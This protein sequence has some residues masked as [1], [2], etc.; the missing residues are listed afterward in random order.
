MPENLFFNEPLARYT[1]WHIGGPAKQ[2]FRPH[3]SADLSAFLRA[4]PIAEPL[5][6]LG[7]GSNV[8]IRDNGF[9]NGYTH[10]Q[11]AK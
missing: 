7:L 1:T 5:F 10:R 2:Y 9:R 6:W 4:L 8:L 11:D 3:D